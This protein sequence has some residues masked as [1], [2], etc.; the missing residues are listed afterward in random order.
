[1]CDIH[2]KK[3]EY[4]CLN[5]EDYYCRQCKLSNHDDYTCEC[6]HVRDMYDRLQIEME[7]HTQDLSGLRERCKRIMDGSFQRNLMYRVKDEEGHLDKFYK[8]MKR[9]LK[10][11]LA[12]VKAFT[13]DTLS[14]DSLKILQNFVSK[15]NPVKFTRK[16]S[17][18]EMWFQLKNVK[19][20]IQ[21]AR[22]MLYGLPNYI[23]ISI[24]PNFMKCLT[25]NGDP[26][27]IRGRPKY[28]ANVSSDEELED[29]EAVTAVV[30]EEDSAGRIFN[31]D[32]NTISNIESETSDNQR[33]RK[34]V[35]AFGPARVKAP[36]TR[37]KS[38]GLGVDFARPNKAVKED[39]NLKPAQLGVYRDRPNSHQSTHKYASKVAAM[40]ERMERG[41]PAVSTTPDTVKRLREAV[42]PNVTRSLP[43]IERSKR[44]PRSLGRRIEKK[45]KYTIQNKLELEDCVDVVAVK[46]GIVLSLG[47]LIQKRDKKTMKIISEMKLSHAGNMCPIHGTNFI[48][49]LQEKKCITLIN[50]VKGLSIVYRIRIEKDYSELCHVETTDS[51]PVHPSFVFAA[52][53]RSAENLPINAVDIVQARETKRPGRPPMFEASVSNVPLYM[54]GSEVQKILGISAFSDGKIVFGVPNALVCVTRT[55]KF[56]WKVALQRDISGVF[57]T[58]NYVYACVQDQRKIMTLNKMGYITEDNIIPD[59]DVIPC[60][61]SAYWDFMTVKDF[62]SKTWVS[63]LFK[64]GVFVL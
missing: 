32:E 3:L 44:R 26:V 19:R 45:G 2:G 60:R 37:R 15:S 48:A 10:E 33:G 58:S 16:D 52:M 40:R 25:Y 17:P 54:Q 24:D 55:G 9:K 61:I 50:T 13:A 31:G 59:L 42:P 63:V 57:C 29:E 14:N 22:Q 20:Q 6:I 34:L 62:K 12:K 64:Y 11:T 8:E 53:Y 38:N 18:R 43:D 56:L 1:M 41:I 23:E 27:I 35:N 46:D 30:Y 5:H 7:E 47:N 36:I 49:V 28:V 4:F 51:G 39:A 21:N